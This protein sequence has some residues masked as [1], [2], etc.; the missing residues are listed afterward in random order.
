MAL[1]PG[2][3]GWGMKLNTHLQLLSRSRKCGSIH[4]LPHT[5]S[6]RSAYLVEHSDNFTFTSP[7]L[8]KQKVQIKKNPKILLYITIW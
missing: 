1:S 2:Q 4:P 3:S 6:W 5:P 7:L 8:L